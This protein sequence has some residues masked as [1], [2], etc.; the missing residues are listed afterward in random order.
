[1][2]ARLWPADAVS[3]DP[4][5]TGRA[6]RQV[7]S[8]DVP[9]ANPARPLGGFSG[10][11]FGVNTS[12]LIT[13]TSTTWT[14]NPHAGV[15]DLEA[16]AIAGVYRYAF[17]A[18]VTGSVPAAGASA[19]IDLISVQLSDPAE[20]DG[21]SAPGVS[22]VYTQ[23]SSSTNPPATP[24]RSLALAQVNV[25]ATGGGSPTVTWVAPLVKP[26]RLVFLKQAQLYALTTVP[27]GT[28]ASVVGDTADAND[29]Y[30]F[31]ATAA[32][33][34]WVPPVLTY[35]FT[36]SAGGWTNSGSGYYFRDLGTFLWPYQLT[37][38]PVV[39]VTREAT[40][41]QGIPIVLD[42]TP[43]V[44]GVAVTASCPVNP[45]SISFRLH[46]TAWVN[47]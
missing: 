45:G 35:R 22:I 3:G 21:T 11:R 1:M 4:S 8:L 20:S 30:K 26:D 13:A 46:I 29:D 14:V 23:G 41:N 5:Y 12:T 37:R 42:I 7:M 44:L 27:L 40:T 6:L 43:D 9:M 25:P 32:G 34:K 19:R 24:A 17:D 36:I 47:E 33:N 38:V 39:Q 16:S 31:I 18:A 15:L 10:V 2:T 28:L